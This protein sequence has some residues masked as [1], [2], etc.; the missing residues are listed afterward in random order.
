MR[1]DDAHNMLEDEARLEAIAFQQ[2]RGTF[3]RWLERHKGKNSPV[4]DLADDI[5][6]DEKF[7]V[8]VKSVEEAVSYLHSRFASDGAVKAMQQAWRQFETAKRA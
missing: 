4:G 6:G 3:H 5:F 1:P 7:P 8:A 2:S